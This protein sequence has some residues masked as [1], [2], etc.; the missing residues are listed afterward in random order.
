MEVMAWYHEV[1]LCGDIMFVN[2]A[3]FLVTIS[4]PE[5]HHSKQAGQEGA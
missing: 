1:T 5:I 4:E 3:I 2:K